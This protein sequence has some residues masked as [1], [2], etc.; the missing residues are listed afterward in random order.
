MKSQVAV[1]FTKIK[2]YASEKDR[3]SQYRFES[4]IWILA[5][6]WL[7]KDSLLND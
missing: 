7:L 4:K 2:Y 6:K 1:L 5:F 3:R